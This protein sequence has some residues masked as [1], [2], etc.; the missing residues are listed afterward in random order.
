MPKRKLNK[1]EYPAKLAC[2]LTNCLT[3]CRFARNC[4]GYKNCPNFAWKE[5]NSDKY[6]II[7]KTN[8]NIQAVYEIK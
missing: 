4:G 2:L 3:S 5:A 7:L 1:N 6:E 8:G